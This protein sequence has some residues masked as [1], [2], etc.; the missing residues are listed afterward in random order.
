[1][2]PVSATLYTTCSIHVGVVAQFYVLV[3][4]VIRQIF[5]NVKVMYFVFLSKQK[6][7]IVRVSQSHRNVWKWFFMISYSYKRHEQNNRFNFAQIDWITALIGKFC[8]KRPVETDYTKFD[9]C[10]TFCEFSTSVGYKLRKKKI[11]EVI[12]LL[13]RRKSENSKNR[14]RSLFMA[15]FLI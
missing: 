3:S 10:K 1:V 14:F 11:F 2:N 9:V 15:I 12:F 4:L 13:G 7:V 6:G 5:W 8:I